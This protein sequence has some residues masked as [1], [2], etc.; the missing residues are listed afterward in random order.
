MSEIQEQAAEYLSRTNWKTFVE[1]LTAEIVFNRP[2]HPAIFCRDL[3]N[4]KLPVNVAAAADEKQAPFNPQDANEWLKACYAD[5]SKNV[6]DNGVLKSK[7]NYSSMSQLPGSGALIEEVNDLKKT[8]NGLQKLLGKILLV[9]TDP[10]L[11][12]SRVK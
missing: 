2:D 5:A 7:T 11:I 12:L 10:E 8:I 1:Y 9:W 6:D 4:S 3:L